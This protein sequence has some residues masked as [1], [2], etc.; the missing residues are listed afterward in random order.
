[1]QPDPASLAQ[2]LGGNGAPPST[3]PQDDGG[4]GALQEVINLMPKVMSALPDPN[5]VHDAATCLR[6]LTGIQKRLMSGGP[7]AGQGS[8]GPPASY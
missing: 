7:G 3:G 1:M 4:L 8:S 5:D 6:V 2:L